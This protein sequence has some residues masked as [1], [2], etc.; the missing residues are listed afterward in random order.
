M[1]SIVAFFT[2]GL[3]GIDT[4]NYIQKLK[5]L[6]ILHMKDPTIKETT[7]PYEVIFQFV[8]DPARRLV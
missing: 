6:Q 5:D 7:L 2:M 4:Y 8:T 3:L 1:G